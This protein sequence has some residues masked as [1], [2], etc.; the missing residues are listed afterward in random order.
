MK[1]LEALKTE[2]DE[3]LSLSR[4]A[5]D[6]DELFSLDP[7]EDEL[8]E[9]QSELGTLEKKISEWDLRTLLGG[10]YD[11]GDALLTIRSG[12]GGT[13]AQD[14]AEML[15]RMYL[16]YAEQIGFRA[17]V[18]DRADG[19]EAGIKQAT[20]EI[21]GRYAYGYLRGEAGVHRLVRLSPF[22]ANNLRQTSFASVEVLPVIEENDTAII[23]NPADLRVDTFR[24]SGAGGQHVNKTE[25]AIRITHIPTNIVVSCQSERSQLQNR[26]EA[27]KILRA[28]LFER[29]EEA[30]R[31]EREKLR[32]EYREAEWG[33]QIRS[34][35]L[36]PYK[37]V[38]DHR[39]EEETS[40][41][42]S[43]LNGALDNFI[44]AE[45]Q[46]LR[47]SSKL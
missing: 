12:A 47:R 20:I 3:F 43:V 28:K 29:E 42:E 30:K 36:H 44:K 35:V 31:K 27:M 19:N 16:R 34:Y 23:I 6:L 24:A 40:D 45:L 13:E 5:K 33:N 25:S 18:L 41:A 32:G 10:T 15:L 4:S 39:T 2:R 7:K 9:L 17:K 38:K 11:T 37:M 22:N 8:A 46:W 26:T 14:W 21:A 1:E